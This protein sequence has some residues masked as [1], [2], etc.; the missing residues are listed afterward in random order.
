MEGLGWGVE[1]GRA[2][3]PERAPSSRGLDAVFD[4]QLPFMPAKDASLKNG[5]DQSAR[6]LT[7]I[8]VSTATT[9]TTLA[10]LLGYLTLAWLPEADG[11]ERS[12]LRVG[13]KALLSV[14][15][16]L[17]ESRSISRTIQVQINPY[18]V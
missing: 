2:R 14:E 6:L 11:N 18:A 4:Y 1:E 16:L 13:K 15:G 10:S 5:S 7:T 12:G 9:G 17:L 3:Q 8:K